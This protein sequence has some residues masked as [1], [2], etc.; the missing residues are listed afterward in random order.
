M[1]EIKKLISRLKS[2]DTIG[3]IQAYK[4]IKE[5]VKAEKSGYRSMKIAILCS[6]TIEGIKETLFV[7]CCE[8]GIHP[9]IYLGNYNQY[10]QEILD[11]GSEFYAFRPDLVILFIDT[12][13]ILGDLYTEPYRLNEQERKQW[14]GSRTREMELLI[15]KIKESLPAKILIHNFE[16]P[17]YSPLGV[18][19]NKEGFGFIESIESLNISIRD[20]FKNDSQTFVLDY[21]SF[22]SRIGKQNIIDYK[23]YYLG[24]MKIGFKYLPE[25]CEEYMAYIKPLMSMTKKCIVLDLD[26]TLW[27]GIIGEDGIEGIKL[28]PAPEGRPFLEFQKYLLSLFE[29]GVILA[30]NS[31]NNYDDAIEVLR[32]HPYMVLREKHF[33]AMQ[34]NWSDKISNMEAIA[35]ELNIGIDALV[36]LDDDL[37][38]R[39]MVRKALPSV[40]VIDLPEDSSLYLKTIMG[41]NDFNTLQ[42]TKEDK[43]KGKIYAEQRK[44]KE[45]ERSATDIIEYLKGLE[46][47]VT[48]EKANRFNIPRISQLTQKTNQFNM[49]TRRYLEEDIKNFS[50][51]SNFLVLSIGVK[52]KFGDNG[53]SGAAIIEKEGKEKDGWRIDTFLLSCRIIG[54]KVE[55]AL[56]AYIAEEALKGNAK[57]LLG[58]F[59]PTKKNAPAKDFY[60]NAG[61]KLLNRGSE[62]ETW[63]LDLVKGHNYPDFIKVIKDN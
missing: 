2:E 19:E 25:L 32:K 13:A 15:R 3:Y 63:Q 51:D 35:Q 23:M 53:I 31:K 40:K 27:G 36:F 61:F 11:K 46:M 38:N 12:R 24:D 10:S 44:R 56:L 5:K 18:L 33:S 9:E 58:E 37:L 30:I 16:V 14:A 57:K 47:R 45:F 49:T 6:F 8:S 26:N 41:I 1:E 39:E 59:I 34:I 42:I 22:C 4:K 60:K 55:E 17:L 43:E 48:I 50:D 29:R 7:K 54:R 21:N 28:G 52:D 62:N 20:I